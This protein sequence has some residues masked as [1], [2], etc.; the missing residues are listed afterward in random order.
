MFGFAIKKTFFDLWDNLFFAMSVNLLYTLATLGLFSLV[1]LLAG[2]SLVGA[3]A[4]WPIPFLAA[5]VLGGAATFWARDIVFTGTA[6]YAEVLSKLGS[7]WRASLVFAAAWMIVGLGLSYGVPFY[8]GV[9]AIVGFVFGIVM[10]WLAFFLAGLGL[11]YPGLN[12]QIEP[13]VGKLFRKAVLVFIANPLTSLVMALVLLL[14]VAISVF[15][16]GFFPGIVG[17]SLW[18]QVCFK[19]VMAKY[20]WLE[21]N[22]EADKKRVPWK[23]ILQEDMEKVGPRSFKGMIFPWKD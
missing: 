6:R 3:L 20:E 13:K 4:L 19:F 8:T 23:V 1:F 22:P 2:T 17:I 18:L 16:L 9:N 14:S 5:S 10:L 21:A 15:T 7:S 11:F 12:A